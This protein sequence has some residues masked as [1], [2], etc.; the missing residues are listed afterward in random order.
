LVQREGTAG[1][2][3]YEF[4]APMAIRS[5]ASGGFGVADVCVLAALCHGGAADG[6][7][8]RPGDNAA[9]RQ[10]G[11]G[12]E[13]ERGAN[14]DEDGAFREV[15]FLHE[16]RIGGGGHSGRGIVV[17]IEF[18]EVGLEAGKIA[19]AAAA[20]SGKGISVGGG[21]AGGGRGFGGFGSGGFRGWS[22]CCLGGS[23]GAAGVGQGGKLGVCC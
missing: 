1:E 15:G 22:C 12:Y 4:A 16:G 8:Q 6:T 19:A 7:V 10:D 9:P 5:A 23:V 3:G 20:E 13:S 2:R 21:Y 17:A 18:G 11:E 14:A